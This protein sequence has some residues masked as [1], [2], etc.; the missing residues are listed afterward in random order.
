MAQSIAEVITDLEEQRDA[1]IARLEVISL[2]PSF[3]I[4]G[5]SVTSEWSELM[6]RWRDIM[7][8]LQRLEGPVCT[9][10]MGK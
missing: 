3:S 4:D 6:Q 2:G 8:M 1:I 5:V 10:T 7:E 9:Y